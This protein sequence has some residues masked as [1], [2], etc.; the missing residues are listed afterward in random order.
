[1]WYESRFLCT[2]CV[3]LQILDCG[4]ASVQSS[5]LSRAA[6]HLSSS[7]LVFY[8]THSSQRQSCYVLT[9][10]AGNDPCIACLVFLCQFFILCYIIAYH[11]C[12]IIKL[13]AAQLGVSQDIHPCHCRISGASITLPAAACRRCDQSAHSTPLHPFQQTPRQS[14]SPPANSLSRCISTKL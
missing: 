11:V 1:M 10:N 4:I 7:G 9:D 14:T 3:S 2:G 12:C 6:P 13:N 5:L 8:P